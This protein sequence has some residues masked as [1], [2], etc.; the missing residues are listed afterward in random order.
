M[1]IR[2]FFSPLRQK[3]K[4]RGFTL[5]EIVIAIVILSIALGTL[6]TV[7]ANVTQQT[8]VPEFLNGASY[9]AERQFEQVTNRRFADVV[10]Q[11]WTSFTGN[12]SDYAY[13]LNVGPVPVSLAA[14]PGM[15]QYKQVEITVRHSS[16]GA[17]SLY[18]IVT[19]Q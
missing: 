4:T 10:S 14:D 3:D 8:V 19:N 18:T 2:S 15:T 16:A 12:F 17:V 9:L 7:I 6:L 5:I 13:Q 1:K 11:G